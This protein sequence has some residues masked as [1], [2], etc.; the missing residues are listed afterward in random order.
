LT[1]IQLW[2]ACFD[3]FYSLFSALY[4]IVAVFA[5]FIFIPFQLCKSSS[6]FEVLAIRA[7]APVLRLHLRLMYAESARDADEFEFKA[8]RIIAV[9]VVSPVVSIGVAF[10]EWVAAPFWIFAI[11]IG[12]PDGTERRDDGKATVLAIR[13]W[14]E[15][16][17]LRA[18]IR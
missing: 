11:I 13:N 4:T 5:L 10:A 16:C 17:L 6:S 1:V 2:L 7:L 14:W 8:G 18:A 15:Q 3:P 12:N 9:Q